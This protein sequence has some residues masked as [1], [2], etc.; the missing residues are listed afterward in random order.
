MLFSGMGIGYI[1]ELI[2]FM[3]R[4]IDI[5]SIKEG[6]LVGSSCFK[7]DYNKIKPEEIIKF[8]KFNAFWKVKK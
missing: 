5:F 3:S 8:D 1:Y 4:F 7:S 2:I 6:E